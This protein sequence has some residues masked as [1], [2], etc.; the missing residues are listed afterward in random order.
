MDYFT[1]YTFP[2]GYFGSIAAILLTAGILKLHFEI[3]NLLLKKQPVK[4]YHIDSLIDSHIW[5][6]FFS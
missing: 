2:F 4:T 3:R 5:M 1:R 6:Q